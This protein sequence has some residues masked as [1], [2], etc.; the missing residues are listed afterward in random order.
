MHIDLIIDV[1]C[2]WCYLGKK[3]LDAALAQAGGNHRVSI[4]PFQL[5]PDLPAEG[6]DRSDYY[7]KKFGN[8]AEL[9]AA[10]DHLAKV[11][12]TYG[13]SFDWR[14]GVTLANTLD[15][16]RVI[17]WAGGA[18]VASAVADGIME[19]YFTKGAFLGDRDLLA[20]LAGDHGMDAALVRSL[21]ETDKDVEAVKV[22]VQQAANMGVQ[23]VPAT[24][25]DHAAILS[26]A[27][28]PAVI[29]QA[30]SEVAQYQTG[31]GPAGQLPKS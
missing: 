13:I 29:I 20:R 11:G 17:R 15:A 6:I 4:R 28:E 1:V 9:L 26:G 16:H 3:Q 22:E 7:R 23:G 5:G 12:E 10:R 30:M 31:Q 18:G 24:I 21:L 25:L 8:S 27:Q 2:P 19:A 14:E